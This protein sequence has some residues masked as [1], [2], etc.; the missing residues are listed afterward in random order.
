[1]P[2][3]LLRGFSKLLEEQRIPK[4]VNHSIGDRFLVK[5]A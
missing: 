2:C 5:I 4:R 3:Q 1:M